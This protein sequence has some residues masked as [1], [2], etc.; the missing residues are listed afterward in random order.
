MCQKNLFFLFFALI[1]ELLI[2]KSVSNVGSQLVMTKINKRQIF[3]ASISKKVY[4]HVLKIIFIR[5]KSFPSA[6]SVFILASVIGHA[7]FCRRY[8]SVQCST[9]AHTNREIPRRMR[10]RARAKISAGAAHTHIGRPELSLARSRVSECD[11]V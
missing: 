11:T 10:A 4:L 9:H 1:F 6:F 2:I 8:V 7:A 3:S 5:L